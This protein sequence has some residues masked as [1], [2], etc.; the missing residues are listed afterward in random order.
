MRR[1]V[2]VGG[3]ISVVSLGGALLGARPADAQGTNTITAT[4]STETHQTITMLPT[5]FV[6]SDQFLTRVTAHLGPNPNLYDQTFSAPFSDPSVQAAIATATTDLQGAGA[7]AIL[8]PS[9][10]SSQTTLVNSVTVNQDTV[11]HSTV[12]V[13]TTAFVGPQCLGVGN[14]DTAQSVPCPPVACGGAP[15]ASSSPCFG[16]PFPIVP[17]GT[18]FDTLTHTEV[19]VN[20][21]PTETDTFLTQAHYDL[22]GEQSIEQVPV[23]ALGAGGLAALG[24]LLVAAALIALRARS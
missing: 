6:R 23:P 5:V 1:T 13:T 15:P 21:V 24:G 17:G 20:R 19:F 11:D 10:L 22:L 14:R 8:G 18:D 12:T 2:G 16:T 4:C 9:L 3:V 7:V